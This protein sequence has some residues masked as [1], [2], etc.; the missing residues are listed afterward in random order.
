M[1]TI[2][3]T[4][5][6]ASQALAEMDYLTAERLCLEALDAAR[7]AGDF[8]AYHRILLPLQ[9]CRRQRRMIACDAGVRTEPGDAA[10][11]CVVLLPPAT[12]D[13]ARALREAARQADHHTEVLWVTEADGERWRVASYAGPEVRA[14]LAAPRDGGPDVTWY[15]RANEALGDAAIAA[16]DAPPGSVDRLDAL[17]R[18]LDVVVD[19]EKLHQ[20]L[21]DAARAL[22]R[23]APAAGGA[24]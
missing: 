23:P 17:A 18:M 8:S 11:G 13:A 19:H 1:A 12:A 5:E 9:E 16:V 10:A 15:L 21:A 14:E 3:D 7:A 22:L 24:A 6:R 4:M 20:R 2:D